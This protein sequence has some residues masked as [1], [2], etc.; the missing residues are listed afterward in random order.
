MKA[1][2]IKPIHAARIASGEKTIELRSRRTHYRGPLLIC[3]CQPDGHARCIVDVIGCRPAT[4]A[5]S[6]AACYAIEPGAKLFAWELANVRQVKPFP[7]K[8]KQGFIDVALPCTACKGTGYVTVRN[9]RLMSAS[10]LQ[11]GA[12]HEEVAC[13]ACQGTGEEPTALAINQPLL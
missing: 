5:D 6:T 13:F 4:P 10:A 2:S 11:Y 12:D 1:L 9:P 3:F 8:G 7:V